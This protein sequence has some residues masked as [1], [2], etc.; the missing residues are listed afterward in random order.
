M[1]RPQPVDIAAVVQRELTRLGV[2]RIA[3]TEFMKQAQL[4]EDEQFF[5]KAALNRKQNFFYVDAYTDPA[6][7]TP[8]VGTMPE[9]S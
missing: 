7:P 9:T 5:F 6:H 1:P 4:S 3:Y 8:M 2:Q